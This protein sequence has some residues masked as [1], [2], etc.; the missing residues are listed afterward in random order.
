MSS[1]K[2]VDFLPQI[3]GSIPP[4]WRGTTFNNSNLLGREK[5]AANLNAL[6]N[7]KVNGDTISTE[8][9]K[10]IGNAEDY[11][12]VS[13]NMSTTLELVLAEQLGLQV[14]QVF[15]FASATMPIV[16]AALAS[17]TGVVQVYTGD[18]PAPFTKAQLPLVQLLGCNISCH[19]GSPP[20]SSAP[21]SGVVLCYH[22]ALPSSKSVAG[23]D[24]IVGPNV[25]YI[26]NPKAIPPPQVLK[27][28][29]R[30]STPVTTPAAFQMLQEMGKLSAQAP[31]SPDA[32][33]V[34][35]FRDHLQQLCGTA[36]DTSAPPVVYTAGLP[37]LSSM[38]LTLV[39]KGG[40]DLV[41]C[42]TAYGGS[43]QLTDILTS[44]SPELFKKHTFD[45][46]GDADIAKSIEG[47]LTTL[48]KKPD[49]LLPM[50]C[51]FVEIPTNPDMKVPSIPQLVAN[52]VNYRNQTGKRVLLMVD[53]TFAPHSEVM[54]QCR[55]ADESL[56]VICFISLSKSVSRGMTTAGAL[57][58]N[59][60]PLAKSVLDGARA[61][62][63]TLDTL[64][65]PDQMQR[66]CDN[67]GGVE[68]RC[69]A[70][71]QVAL[72]AGDALLKAVKTATGQTMVLRIV[73]PADAAKGFT[74][75]S[76]SF[77]LPSKGTNADVNANL[78]QDF[79]D[80]L[81]AHAAEF[82][83][84]VSF[85]QDNGIVYATV[86]ATSTQGALKDA[87]KAKQ[88]VGGVQLTRLSFPASCDVARVSG[89]LADSIATLYKQ[90]ARL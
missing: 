9:L 16:T 17:G 54:R 11:F 36:S 31:A 37:A 27:F 32:K 23:I 42:S 80:L 21:P 81:C 33:E 78:A 49:N 46:Q 38:Y 30:M 84:C 3:L 63:T 19:A 69:R 74:T 34:G 4:A 15:T 71:Y 72:A 1:N 62:G 14:A 13:S 73:S 90:S 77:N 65:R 48:A 41:I 75:S 76:F 86:P 40:T 6:V 26:T 10:A 43:N 59:H 56:A 83:P 82:K 88:A 35:L 22:A 12:R 25:L 44:R 18:E 89:I 52:L 50:T 87:D 7:T 53:T 28:R 85:G 24:G 66:L 57:I 67:H 68:K 45:I 61:T 29:K 2:V 79:V 51:L 58:A 20:V 64:A 55:E 39:A 8:E 47:R 5:F 70:V 60:T